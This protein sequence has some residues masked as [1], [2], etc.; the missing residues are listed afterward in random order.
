[1]VRQEAVPYKQV[2]RAEGTRRRW[3]AI[4]RAATDGK[5]IR[6]KY[7]SAM[8]K[9]RRTSLVLAILTAAIF[10]LSGPTAHSAEDQPPATKA[11]ACQAPA[12]RVVVDVGH[13]VDVPGA[14]SARGVPE[15]AFNLQL[16][17]VVKQAL[18]ASGFT[19]TVRLITATAPWAGLVERA[20][21][22]N[23]MRADLFISIHHDSVPDNLI[24]TWEF[25][26]EKH[27]FSDRF[28]GYSIFISDANADR[29]GSLAFGHLLGLELQARGMH[30]TPH[31]TL[32][33]MGRHRHQLLD[34]DAGVYRYDQLVVL[35]NT[36]MPAVLLEAGSIVNR[37]E[38]LELA[39]TDRRTRIAAA[40]V[41][42]V[43]QFCAERAEAKAGRPPTPLTT[44]AP[45]RARPALVAH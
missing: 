11:T 14:D 44:S 42:A 18:V 15:Y 6:K 10:V 39:S 17:D 22:A 21:R 25:N 26:G 31:Y 5:L 8:N 36:L 37:Q 12:F 20:A 24:E 13:T 29:K 2:L 28:R 19:K 30:Y 16:A 34:A 27:Q 43:E 35:R 1:L 33:L 32:P 41:A 23:A 4:A 40:I 45:V 7:K 9:F 38:E 3:R